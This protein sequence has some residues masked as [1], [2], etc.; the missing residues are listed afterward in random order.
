MGWRSSL[1]ASSSLWRN[2][3]SDHGGDLHWAD[4]VLVM[5]PKYAARIRFQ[6]PAESIPPM[7]SLDIPDDYEY[8]DVELVELIKTAVEHELVESQ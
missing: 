1:P 4:L 5:E 6:F 2:S 7:R 8:M 3:A